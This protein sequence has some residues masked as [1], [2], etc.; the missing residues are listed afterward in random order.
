M[1]FSSV[2]SRPALM[3]IQFAFIDLFGFFTKD[4]PVIFEREL[5]CYAFKIILD[6]TEKHQISLDNSFL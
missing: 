2:N 1:G 6:F 3:C 5:P 4:V